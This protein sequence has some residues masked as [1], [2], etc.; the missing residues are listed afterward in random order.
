[1][2]QVLA[3]HSDEGLVLETSAFL[4][5]YGDNSTFIKSFHTTKLLFHSST[6]A[7]PQFL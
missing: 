1:M 6:E 3:L 2:F 7:A 5:F 4:I